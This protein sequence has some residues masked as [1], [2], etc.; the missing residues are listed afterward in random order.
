MPPKPSLLRWQ[1]KVPNTE[2]LKQTNFPSIITI[3]H[4]AQLR[5]AGQVSHMPDD[6]IPK[7]LLYG[8]LCRG[9]CTVGGQRKRFKDSLKVS[10][11]DLNIST[12]S[13]ESL[14][15]DRP[16]WC[17]LIIKGAH[18]AEEHRS[19]QAEQ[20]RAARKAR[21]TSTNSTAPTHFCPTY[22]RGFIA[23]IGLISHL[24][25]HRSSSSAN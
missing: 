14:A 1:D 8:E 20:K 10:L 13:W 16:S 23:W 11:K 5:R 15:S 3:M 9:N 18:A 24:W 17:H 2:V 6:H 22:R 12:E 7:Q 25:K 4:K 21:A 19:L